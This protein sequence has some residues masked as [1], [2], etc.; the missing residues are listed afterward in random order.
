MVTFKKKNKCVNPD[1]TNICVF[2]QCNVSTYF[3]A[4]IKNEKNKQ[5]PGVD[6]S[7]ETCKIIPK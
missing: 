1:V 5:G 6:T 2:I 4:N 7:T 3:Q